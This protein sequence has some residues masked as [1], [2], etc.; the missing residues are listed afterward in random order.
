MLS[1]ACGDKPS[2]ERANWE[3][4]PSPSFPFSHAGSGNIKRTTDETPQLKS[5]SI[6]LTRKWTRIA[7]T[8]AIAECVRLAGQG[9]RQSGP[10]ALATS[11]QLL[12]IYEES[13]PGRSCNHSA[14][15]FF[16]NFTSDCALEFHWS[17]QFLRTE[18][19]RKTLEKGV[20]EIASGAPEA[21]AASVPSGVVDIWQS[22]PLSFWTPL[23][24][25]FFFL[26]IF[27]GFGSWDGVAEKKSE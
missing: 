13:E 9:V 18:L 22:V 8:S 10:L 3:L 14:F 11:F 20:R 26:F 5:H 24:F 21:A 17:F 25:F 27:F 7:L 6:F 16:N 15:S 12:P 19:K 2:T 23:F 4:R 1:V